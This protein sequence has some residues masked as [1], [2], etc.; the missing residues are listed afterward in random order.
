M[1]HTAGGPVF[2]DDEVDGLSVNAP[3]EGVTDVPAGSET[4]CQWTVGASACAG[5]TPIWMAVGCP[6]VTV[7]APLGDENPTAGKAPLP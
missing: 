3:D 1:G 7:T 5:A 4:T 6:T 2:D